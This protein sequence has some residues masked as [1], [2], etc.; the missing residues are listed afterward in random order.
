M[1]AQVSKQLF[2][3]E[4]LKLTNNEMDQNSHVSAFLP[5]SILVLRFLIAFKNNFNV[6]Y[7]NSPFN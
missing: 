7:K 5:Y 3:F 2:S 6:L 4:K 1:G